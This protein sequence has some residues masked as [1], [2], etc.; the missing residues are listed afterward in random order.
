M[1]GIAVVVGV[2]ESEVENERSERAW[3]SGGALLGVV[4]ALEEVFLLP[5]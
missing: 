4:V 2:E 5:S 1:I 3:W